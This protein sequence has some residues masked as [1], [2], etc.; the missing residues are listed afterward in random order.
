MSD[1]LQAQPPDVWDGAS[2]F[3][4]YIESTDDLMTVVDEQARFVYVNPVAERVFGLSAEEC[5]G[6]SAF[7][8]VHPDDQGE[9][10]AAFA[11]WLRAGGKGAFTFENRQVSQ[12]GEVRYFAWTVTRQ[13]ASGSGPMLLTSCAHDITDL[14]RIQQELIR[15]ECRLSAL[16]GGMLDAVITI[17]ST[18]I[19]QSASDSVKGMFGYEVDELL[20]GNVDVLMPEPHR[21]NHDAYMRRYRETGETWILGRTR[22]FEVLRKCGSAI[23]C[24]ISIS[25][26]DIPGEE[27]PLFCG[28]FRDVTARRVAE[29]ALAASEQRFRAIFEQE[30]QLVVLL[31]PDGTVRDVN[32]AAALMAGASR[33]EIVG[34]PFWDSPPWS[35]SQAARAQLREWVE[36]AGRGEVVREE[37]DFKTGTEVKTIDFSLKPIQDEEGETILL[38]AEGREITYLKQ[39]QRRETAMLRALASIGE[40]AAVLAHEIKNPITAVN[41]ALRAVAAQ[42]GEED[43]AV[44]KELVGSMERLQ[45][46]MKRTLSFARP[47]DLKPEVCEVSE[48]FEGPCSMLTPELEAAGVDLDVVV[49]PDCPKVSVDRHL[50]EEV[51]TNLV[52]N[53]IEAQDSGGHIRLEAGSCDGGGLMIRIEDDGPGIPEGIRGTLFRPFLTTKA[54]GTGIGLALCKKIVEEHG[55][56]IEAGASD[57]GGASFRITMPALD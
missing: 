50:M 3:R 33:K 31:G 1:P 29:K 15:S 53:S 22:E 36:Q 45:G 42:L 41:M 17:D 30:Y 34:K 9:T 54:K 43:Q 51:V 44:L 12:T 49:A 47:L 46:M 56:S 37:V 4:K 27:E 39:A 11:G 14:R 21:S 5:R 32:Q 38:I 2:P 13:E 26:V 6:R 8:F 10:R 23:T 24:E 57:S 18:G 48:L 20:G 25:R 52:K 55:G 19:I 40:S 16:L 28:S 7:D 35:R